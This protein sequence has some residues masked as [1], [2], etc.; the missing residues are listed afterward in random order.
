MLCSVCLLKHIQLEIFVSNLSISHSVVARWLTW[1]KH[2]NTHVHVYS[3]NDV[4]TY[5]RIEGFK[6]QIC[7]GVHGEILK[8]RWRLEG[9]QKPC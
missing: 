3:H 5:D 4:N 2:V 1:N 9:T 8:R 7:C 6:L